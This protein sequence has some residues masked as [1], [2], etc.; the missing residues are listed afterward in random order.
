MNYGNDDETLAA[1]RDVVRFRCAKD[2]K[3]K[4]K[5]GKKMLECLIDGLMCGKK[6]EEYLKFN[7]Y[8]ADRMIEQ[9]SR[10]WEE[11]PAW[12][13]FTAHTKKA[14]RTK[15][16]LI[17]MTAFARRDYY[18]DGLAEEEEDGEGLPAYYD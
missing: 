5:H 17:L 1:A 9:A 6:N 3:S 16:M 7:F 15:A 2:K 13:Q 14:I 8:T 18:Y 4:N 12:A 11:N 10:E